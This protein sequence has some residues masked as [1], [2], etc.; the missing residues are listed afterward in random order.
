MVSNEQRAVVSPIALSALF[1]VAMLATQSWGQE[2][3][4]KFMRTIRS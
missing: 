2:P 3:E 4:K 1:A